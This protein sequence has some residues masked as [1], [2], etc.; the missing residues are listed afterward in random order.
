MANSDQLKPVHSEKQP[1]LEIGGLSV[2]F[3][4][5]AQ[6]QPLPEVLDALCLTIEKVRDEILCSILL[7]D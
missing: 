6:N 1:E 3:E 4:K 5:L 2:V 7:V